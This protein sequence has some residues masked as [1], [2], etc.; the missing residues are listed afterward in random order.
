M[1]GLSTYIVTIFYREPSYELRAGI[2]EEPYSGSYR[3]Q[4]GSQEESE[5]LALEQFRR[6]E[7]GSQVSWTRVVE[8]VESRLATPEENQS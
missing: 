7:N 4:A 3:I 1:D 8:K 6:Q 2:K 5:R